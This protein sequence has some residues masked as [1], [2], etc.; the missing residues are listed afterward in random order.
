MDFKVG[1]ALHF[2]ENGDYNIMTYT[3]TDDILKA[4][5]SDGALLK[6]IKY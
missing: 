4:Y 1:G 2:I 3:L 5:W 6:H